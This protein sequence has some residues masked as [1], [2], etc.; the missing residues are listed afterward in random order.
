MAG[1][2]S[3]LGGSNVTPMPPLSG[4]RVTT[5]PVNIDIGE[6]RVKYPLKNLSVELA[7]RLQDDQPR[8]DKGFVGGRRMSINYRL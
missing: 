3:Y 7:V 6:A 5:A 8:P 1:Y 4:N 2:H